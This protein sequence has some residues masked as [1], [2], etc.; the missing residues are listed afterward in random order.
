MMATP[1]V[2][3]FALLNLSSQISFF[4]VLTFVRLQLELQ[5]TTGEGNFP[6]DNVRDDDDEEEED[7][8]TLSIRIAFSLISRARCIMDPSFFS[9]CIRFSFPDL[10]SGF[11]SVRQK[12]E[13]DV[14][15]KTE[16]RE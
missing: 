6:R 12:L 2:C 3:I 14:V 4:F 8:H 10:A 11:P 7:P 13:N 1:R 9:S 16:T 15:G 5:S